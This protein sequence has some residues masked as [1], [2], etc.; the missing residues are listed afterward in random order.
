MLSLSQVKVNFVERH[1]VEQLGLRRGLVN[2]AKWQQGLIHIYNNLCT[3]GRCSH[4]SLSQL[5]AGNYVQI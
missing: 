1:M 5:E 4:C 2:S 3:R